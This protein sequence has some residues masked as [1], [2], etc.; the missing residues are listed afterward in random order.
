MKITYL[1]P[2]SLPSQRANAIQVMKTC[3]SLAQLGHKVSLVVPGSAMDN[4]TWDALADL[5]GLST[6]FE[7]HFLKPGLTG[8][9]G[10]A[11]EAAREARRMG[12][13]LVFT[14]SLP[15]AVT[16]LRMKLPAILEMHQM[17]GGLFGPVWFRWF[18]RLKGRK[19]LLTITLALSDALVKA[20]PRLSQGTPLLVA[21]SGVDLERYANL[22]GAAE[23]RRQL[24]LP[25]TWSAVCTGNLYPGRGMDLVLD[26]ARRLPQVMFIWVGGTPEDVSLWKERSRAAGME[27]IL[28]TGFIAN[29]EMPLYQAAADVLLLPYAPAF[30]NSGGEDISA[31]SSPLKAFEYLAAGRPICSSDLPVLREVLNESNAVLLPSGDAEAWQ[32]ALQQLHD[33]PEKWKALSQQASRDAKGYSWQERSR[34]VLEKFQ[35]GSK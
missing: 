20:Y 8:R 11:R 29:R 18:I 7:L 23:A 6:P 12:T 5:Y 19:L 14:R 28:L 27:N 35:E 34:K 4:P 15:A 9:R 30:T 31:V 2:S 1:Y 24:G 22:P 33:R 26:L 32:Q 21:P 17:P 13:D 3:Q 10:F 16:S 25:E